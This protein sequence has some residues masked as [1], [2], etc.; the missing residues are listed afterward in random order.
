MGNSQPKQAENP[1]NPQAAHLARLFDVKTEMY[2]VYL[3]IYLLYH[4]LDTGW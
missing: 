3:S 4:C 1:E 2:S